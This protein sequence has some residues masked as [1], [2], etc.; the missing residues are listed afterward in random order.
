MTITAAWVRSLKN[1][2]ELIVASDSRLNGGKKLDCGQKIIALPRSDAFICFAGETDWAY[3]LMH[4]VISAISTYE[5]SRS[6]AQDIVELKTH[7]LKIFE[8]LRELIH[9]AVEGQEIPSAE[10]LFGG[11]S[12]I[13]QKFMIWHIS[14]S[15]GMDCFEARPAKEWKGQPWVFAGDREHVERARLM[16][17]DKLNDKGAGPHQVNPFKIDWE[18]FEVIRDMLVEVKSNYL[19]F[20]H[21]SIG[22]APQVLK[23]YQH[24]SSQILGVKW[25]NNGDTQEHTY[26]SGRKALGYETPDAWVLDPM[27]LMTSHPRYSASEVE[28]ENEAVEE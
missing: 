10:F 14:Y 7:V 9:D 4:Q 2:K 11:Y 23:I 3:P 18:P 21:G 26:I 12:W 5:K 27:T 22:G 17:S 16:F 6:R 24:L 28:M 13:R 1:Y 25:S 19:K 20:E 8:G 15:P